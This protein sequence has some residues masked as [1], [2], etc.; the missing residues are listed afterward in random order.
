M[1][2]PTNPYGDLY[3]LTYYYN[4]NN[5]YG[6][7]YGKWKGFHGTSKE[8]NLYQLNLE[9]TSN[10]KVKYYTLQYQYIQGHKF[11]FLGNGILLQSD[12]KST[13]F[14]IRPM[15]GLSLMGYIKLGYSYSINIPHTFDGSSHHAIHFNF[16]LFR[17]TR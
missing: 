10:S 14:K 11:F 8:K 13:T 4:G 12:F 3:G 16:Y 7:F 9:Y 6:L 17:K 5:N 1:K 2:V 15:A